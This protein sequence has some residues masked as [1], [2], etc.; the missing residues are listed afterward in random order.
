[1]TVTTLVPINNR[2]VAWRGS[3]EVSREL[4]SR[5]DRLHWFRVGVL[6]LIFGLLTVAT[7]AAG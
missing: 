3:G 4:A 6:V 5:W 1:V 2:I 7:V